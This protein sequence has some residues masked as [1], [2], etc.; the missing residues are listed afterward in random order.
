MRDKC[1]RGGRKLYYS[2]GVEGLDKLLSGGL[3]LGENVLW[4]IETGTF[5][6]EFLL[7]FMKQGI[8]EDDQVIFLDFIYPPQALIILLEPLTK[9]LTK[10]WEEKLL[11]LDCFSESAGLGELIFSDFYDTAPNWLRKVPS[12]EDPERFHHFFG[13]IEREFISERTRLVFNSLTAME[14]TWGS[15]SAKAFFRHVCPALYA[16]KTL[17]YWTVAKNAHSREFLAIIEHMTQV[18]IDLSTEEDKLDLRIVKTGRRYNP[19]IR[20]SKEYT[21]QG[22]KIKINQ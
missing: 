10:G 5:A 22:L 13:R 16:Y 3:I 18:V 19:Q 4:E 1:F 12:S 11:V 21:V 7:A 2:T 17:A 20:R 8:E 14:H 9:E 6:Q 15:E